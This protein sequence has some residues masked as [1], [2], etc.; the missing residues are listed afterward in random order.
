VLWFSDMSCSSRIPKAVVIP[1]VKSS[2]KFF[3]GNRLLPNCSCFSCFSTPFEVV[4]FMSIFKIETL[5]LKGLHCAPSLEL[6]EVND[7]HEQLSFMKR[8]KKYSFL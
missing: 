7:D 6:R 4:E 8:L 5:T 3:L 1:K 2:Y